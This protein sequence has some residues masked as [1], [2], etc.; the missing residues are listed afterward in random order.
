MKTKR[1]VVIDVDAIAVV[2]VVV[3]VAVV[4]SMMFSSLLLSDL[5]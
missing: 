3:V 4:A 2:A 1:T 5:H